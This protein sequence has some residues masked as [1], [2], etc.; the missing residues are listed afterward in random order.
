[1]ECDA[2]GSRNVTRRTVEGFLLEECNLCGNLQGDD[3][4][5]ARVEEIRHGRARGLDDRVIPLVSALE[6][7]GVFR[8]S[9]ASAGDPTRNEPPYVF[10]ALLKNDTTYIE[11]LLR[12]LEMANRE[13]RLRWLVELSLQHGIVYILRPRFYKSPAEITPEDLAAAQKDLGILGRSLRRDLGLSWW[14]S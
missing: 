12:S 5:V 8:V 9:Q 1:M 10:F 13:T 6:D 3:A 7:S 4:A 14:R 2:C 11:R